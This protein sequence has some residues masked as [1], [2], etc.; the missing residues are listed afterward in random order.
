MVRRHRRA[1]CVGEGRRVF[2]DCEH[3]FDG[4]RFDPRLRRCGCSRP[5]STAGADVGG[6]VRHQRRH[7]AD[8]RRTRSSREV[9]GADR[10]PARH[11]LP[12]RHRLRG[13]Q[14]GRRGRRPARRTCSAPPTATASG[15]ATP[16]CSPSSATWST[17]LGLP[18]LPDGLPGRDD[19][20]LARHRRDRQHRPRHPPGLRRGRPPSRTRRACTRARSRSTRSCTTTWTRRWSATTCGSWSPRWPAGPSSSSRPASS[21]S[22]WPASPT[23]VGRV[24]ERVKE[25]RRDGWSFEAADASF[26]LLVRAELPATRRRRR[27]RSSPTG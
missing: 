5:R 11:P 22:T 2:L 8:G 6:A 17:K 9:R 13:G 23:R 1:S 7:A 18:V 20:G 26:E 27:S 16:T 3:F 10:L 21:A 4:Y 24:V 15:P 25:R 19:A 12:G 14:H